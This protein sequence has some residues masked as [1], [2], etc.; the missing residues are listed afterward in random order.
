MCKR[1]LQK[2]AKRG[3]ERYLRRLA[4]E[5]RQ[6]RSDE[7]REEGGAGTKGRRVGRRGK[8]VVRLTQKAQ[9]PEPIDVM[10]RLRQDFKEP[11]PFTGL[12]VLKAGKKR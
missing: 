12:D 8:T 10:K 7:S 9:S 4:G 2:E 1:H 6:G 5:R 3:R 11:L